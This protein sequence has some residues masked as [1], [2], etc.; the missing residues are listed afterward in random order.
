MSIR[1]A[2]Q[3]LRPTR[4]R[5]LYNPGERERF[6]IR[7]ASQKTPDPLW[8]G[9]HWINALTLCNAFARAAAYGGGVSICLEIRQHDPAGQGAQ[10]CELAYQFADRKMRRVMTMNSEITG[11][12]AGEAYIIDV[13]I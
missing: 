10:V 6:D 8:R 12:G 4:Q 11:A 2:L 1:D 7:A 5:P 13:Q 3:T 9:T